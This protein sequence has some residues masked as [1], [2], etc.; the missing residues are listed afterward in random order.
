MIVSPKPSFTPPYEAV[1]STSVEVATLPAVPLNVPEVPPCGIVIDDGTVTSD[2]EATR[3]IV[4]PPLG[5]AIV[6]AT[7]HEK[8]ESAVTDVE[9]QENPFKPAG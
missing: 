4:A 8:P 5:A 1:N 3:D 7:V 6:R 2:G 9:V